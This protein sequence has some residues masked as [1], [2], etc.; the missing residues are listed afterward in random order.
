MRK[1]DILTETQRSLGT[2]LVK[3]HVCEHCRAVYVDQNQFRV[4]MACQQCGKANT[5]G[6]RQYFGVA[7]WSLIDLMQEFFHKDSDASAS[8]GSQQSSNSPLAVVLFFATLREVLL[9]HFLTEMM[10]AHAMTVAVSQRLFADNRSH[11]Q[12]LNNLFPSLSGGIKW[13]SAL[14]RIQ[15]R[16]SFT[17]SDLNDFLKEVADA[18][19]AFLHDGKQW[20]ITPDMAEQCMLRIPEVIEL[21]VALHNEFVLQEHKRRGAPTKP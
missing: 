10:K 13:K 3:H 17:A 9:K 16:V 19:N 6:H 14:T 4:G 21:Y 15:C 11:Q 20:A 7:V 12:M 1:R 8:P 5:A 2:A 18:R